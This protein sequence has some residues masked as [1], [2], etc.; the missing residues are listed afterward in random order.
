MY[1]VE[2][3]KFLTL[4]K[5]EI[6]TEKDESTGLIYEQGAEYGT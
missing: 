4:N 6:W 5:I 3:S 2:K 1:T